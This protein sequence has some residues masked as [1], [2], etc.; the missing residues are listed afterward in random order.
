MD[1]GA[2]WVPVHGVAKSRIQQQITFN[3]QAVSMTISRF[4]HIVTRSTILFFFMVEE[5]S[6]VPMYYSFS[7]YHIHLEDGVF[8]C[9]ISSIYLNRKIKAA[10]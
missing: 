9:F 10:L 2:W 4:I 3:I 6:V 5:Y 8:I 1:R 7:F